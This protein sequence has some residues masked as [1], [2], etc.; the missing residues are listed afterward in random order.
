MSDEINVLSAGAIEPGLVDSAAAF[1]ELSGREVKIT[2]ATTPVILK[3]IGDGDKPD[4]V[5]ANREA[6]EKLVLARKLA[7]KDGVSVGRVGIGMVVRDRAPA[8]DI[9]SLGALKYALLDADSVVFNRASSGLQVERILREMGV[10]ER[11]QG[12]VSRYNNGPAMMDHLM[13]GKVQ[14]KE[15]GFGAIVEIR[16]FA[17]QGLRLAA[18]LP[19]EVQ[20]YTEYV[21]APMGAAADPDG[22]E[23][24]VAFLGTPEAR[25]YFAACGVE[26]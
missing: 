4:V 2:W 1:R 18:P 6:F 11:I 19:P 16:M 22:A 25:G 10:F 20:Y 26:E 23:A 3:R 17:D 14:G 5:I 7:A 21:A 9:S 15:I 24:F 8:P 13:A 12:K